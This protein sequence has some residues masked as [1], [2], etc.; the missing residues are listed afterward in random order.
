VYTYVQQGT[1]TPSSAVISGLSDTSQFYNGQ[2]VEGANI[3]NSTTVV[4]VTSTTV[5]MSQTATGG[6]TENITFFAY[7]NCDGSTTFGIPDYRGFV[8]SGRDTPAAPANNMQVATG[9]TTTNGSASAT[10]DS[11]AGL[12]I[13]MTVVSANIPAGYTVVG[14]SGTTVTLNSGTN[15]GAGTSVAARF[16]FIADAQGLGAKGGSITHTQAVSE[17]ATHTPSGSVSITD[18]THTHQYTPTA[19]NNQTVNIVGG[20]NANS[21]TAAAATTTASTTGI[22][23]SFSGN[24]VGS[25]LPAQIQQPTK[26]VNYIVRI[27]P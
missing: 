20:G 21:G 23:A 2:P 27:L 12:A 8:L 5:T 9:V 11:A 1:L 22:T 4:S 6:A 16:G 15:V 13:G 25:S 17:I 18:P 10:V 7:S 26:N 3:P 24:S 19:N 14:I